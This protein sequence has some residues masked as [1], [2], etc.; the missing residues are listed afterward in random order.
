MLGLLGTLSSTDGSGLGCFRTEDS[1]THLHSTL[2]DIQHII[3]YRV[4]CP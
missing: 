2:K 1:S 3:A 4:K